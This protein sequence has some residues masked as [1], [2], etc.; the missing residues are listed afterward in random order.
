MTK[1]NEV[2]PRTNEEIIISIVL[3]ILDLFILAITLGTFSVLVKQAYRRQNEFI[4]TLNTFRVSMNNMKIPKHLQ[5]E[6]IEHQISIQATQEQQ[7]ELQKFLTM[8]SPSLKQKVAICLFS[9]VIKRNKRLKRVI[10]CKMRDFANNDSLLHKVLK[11]STTLKEDYEI[12]IIHFI[13]SRLDTALS[14][15][16]DVIIQQYDESNDMYIIAKGECVVEILNHKKRWQRNHKLLR[17][18]EYFGEI[19]L[20]YN[21][22]RTAT[23]YSRKYTTLAKLTQTKFKEINTEYPEIVSIFKEGILKYDYQYKRFMK[24]T[25]NQIPFLKNIDGSSFIDVLYSMQRIIYDKGSILMQPND[26]PS[27]LYILQDGVIEVF[28]Y[29]EEHEFIIETLHRGSII[30]YRTFFMQDQV[31]VYFRFARKSIL[32]VISFQTLQSICDNN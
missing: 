12:R 18:G 15:P 11:N 31:Q 20:I 22:T 16:D 30:N 28:T 9:N 32:Q 21:C 23:V 19:S 17:I 3:L 29:F 26:N 13:A 8:I 5:K 6:V 7:E 2:S 4:H 24:T 25:L 27:D 14:T 1:A 10:D